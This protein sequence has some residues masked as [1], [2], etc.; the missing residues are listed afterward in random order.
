LL[1]GAG[2]TRAILL[3]T[4]TL[5]LGYE[6]GRRVGPVDRL[7]DAN[8]TERRVALSS[9][10]VDLFQSEPLTGVGPGRFRALSPTALADQ[11]ARWA[12]NEYLEVAAET[13]VFGLILVVGLVL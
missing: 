10:T 5:G 1:T 2:L 4:A 8:L 7:L 3:A 13:G 12:H 9:D 11:D 6:P